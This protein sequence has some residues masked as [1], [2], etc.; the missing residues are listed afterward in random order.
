LL[1]KI[2]FWLF[3][4]SSR[5]NC[6]L[7]NPERLRGLEIDSSNFAVARLATQRIWHQVQQAPFAARSHPRE[8]RTSTMNPVSEKSLTL[9]RWHHPDK[10]SAVSL[11][12]AD[13]HIQAGSCQAHEH[14]H[15]K[16][17]N[18]SDHI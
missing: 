1:K 8:S 12:E 2:Y 5:C 14:D 15:A 9:L 17:A 13:T 6:G 16:T 11:E 18:H 7:D 10:V 3:T 4:S